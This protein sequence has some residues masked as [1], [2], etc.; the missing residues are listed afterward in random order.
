MRAVKDIAIK[1][2]GVEGGVVGVGE[3]ADGGDEDIA[4]LGLV[5]AG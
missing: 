5:F 3:T 2:F 4:C 1:V